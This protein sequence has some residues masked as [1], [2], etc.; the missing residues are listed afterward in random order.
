[1]NYLFMSLWSKEFFL[2]QHNTFVPNIL[3][4]INCFIEISGGFL[5]LKH[6]VENKGVMEI[7]SSIGIH[8][9]V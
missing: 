4:I 8:K 3:D 1:M 7:N 5:S 2:A 9:L 6:S